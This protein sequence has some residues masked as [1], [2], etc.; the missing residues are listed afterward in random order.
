MPS[1]SV[2]LRR[3]A[4]VGVAFAATSAPSVAGASTATIGPVT[5]TAEYGNVW[6]TVG[7]SAGC[8]FSTTG[9]LMHWPGVYCF[10]Y[11]HSYAIAL[12]PGGPPQVFIS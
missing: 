12:P 6:I 5:Y 2:F 10:A 11:G 8:L 4:V 1:L 7:S 9:G 3:A